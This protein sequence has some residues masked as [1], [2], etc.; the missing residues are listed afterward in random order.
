[1]NAVKVAN[2]NSG[3]I[4]HVEY[5]GTVGEDDGVEVGDGLGEGEAEGVTGGVGVGVRVGLGAGDAVGVGFGLSCAGC[6]LKEKMVI[7]E[8]LMKKMS[9]P[10]A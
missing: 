5:S 8:F 10:P 2:V 4:A 6:V 1:M 7:V 3:R 9:M